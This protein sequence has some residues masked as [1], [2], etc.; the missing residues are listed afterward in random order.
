MAAIPSAPRYSG[1]VGDRTQLISVG[2]QWNL[3]MQFV[4]QRQRDHFERKKMKAKLTCMSE[5]KID[6]GK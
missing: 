2:V 6:P 5:M 1:C 3:E 4:H